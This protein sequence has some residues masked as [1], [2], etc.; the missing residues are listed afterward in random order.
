[1]IGLFPNLTQ[2][3][4]IF[5]RGFAGGTKCARK[6]FTVSSDVV[7]RDGLIAVHQEDITTLIVA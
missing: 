3:I 7:A 4:L 6:N 2:Q 1:M 5:F